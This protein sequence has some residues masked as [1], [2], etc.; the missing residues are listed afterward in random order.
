[1][2]KKPLTQKELAKRKKALA[3]QMAANGQAIPKAY[4]GLFN[5]IPSVQDIYDNPIVQQQISEGKF[6]QSQIDY[7]TNQGVDTSGAVA[8]ESA[9]TITGGGG[10]DSLT[11]STVT[12][13]GGNDTLDTLTGGA[14]NDTLTT[15]TVIGG[16]GNDTLDTSTVIGGGGND[17][18]DTVTGGGG[19]DTLTTSTVTGGG[20]N[21]SL[22]TSTVTGGGGNDTLDTLTGGNG[23]DSLNTVTDTT[24]VKYKYDDANNGFSADNKTYVRHSL[25]A[26]GE[27]ISTDY[28]ANPA[29]NQPFDT[30]TIAVDA[31][32]NKTVAI[33]NKYGVQINTLYLGPDGS[34]ID[35]SQIQASSTDSND[36]VWYLDENYN[37][38]ETTRGAKP[39]DT[40][41]FESKELADSAS[42]SAFVT[43]T[44]TGGGGNDTIT[45]GDGNDAIT[46]DAET[47]EPIPE[48]YTL[49]Y[50]IPQ[51]DGSFIYV[52]ANEDG[53]LL[54]RQG[55]PRSGITDL[56]F[57]P[58]D[59]RGYNA[60][61]AINPAI[62]ERGIFRYQDQKYNPATDQLTGRSGGLPIYDDDGKVVGFTEGNQSS[63][64][65]TQTGTDIPSAAQAGTPIYDAAGEI[66]GY[67][68]PQAAGPNQQRPI[69]NA[70]G[71][72]T[73]YTSG[74]QAN[75]TTAQRVGSPI[76]DAQGNIIGYNNQVQTEAQ[77]RL[78]PIVDDNGTITG[79]TQ[80]SGLTRESAAPQQVDAEG[81]LIAPVPS[82][83]ALINAAEAAAIAGNTA[84]PTAE[85]KATELPNRAGMIADE[86]TIVRDE[87]G[88]I[89]GAIPA[90]AEIPTAATIQ[91]LGNEAF[92]ILKN[93]AG[94]SIVPTASYTAATQT[95]REQSDITQEEKV[96][97]QIG[98]D[99]DKIKGSGIILKAVGK[100]TK[101]LDEIELAAAPAVAQTSDIVEEM[102]PKA[103]EGDVNALDTVRGQLAS[104]MTEFDDGTPDWAAG[105]IRVANQIMAERGLGNSSMAGAAILQAAQEAAL[106]I[107]Q[108]DAQV[109]ANMNLTNLSNQNKFAIDNAAAARNFKLS[110]L[111]NKQQAELSNS[112]QRFNFLQASLS[113]TQA[114]MV[115]NAQMSNALQE[116]DL[117]R[118]QQEQIANAARYSE[119]EN[120]NLTHDQQRRITDATNQ[121]QVNL[122][123]LSTKEKAVLAELQVQAAL[124]G[125]E[126]NNI[127]QT[128][129]LKATRYAEANNLDFTAEQ[130]RVFSNSKMVETIA[131]DN[132]EFNQTRTL[133]NAANYATMDM[134]NL[135]NRQQAQVV[136]AQSF[137]QMDLANLS[138]S[139]Q[140]T[141]LDAQGLQQFM[142][143]DTAAENAARQFNATSQN[144]V[145][146]FYEG[147]VADISK[148][149]SN[150]NAAMQQ[151]NAGQTNAMEQ[152]NATMAN[153]REQF[154]AANALEI[155][156]SNVAFRRELNTL[157]SAGK[158]VEAQA[159]AE[160]YFNMSQQA[161]AN[162]WQDYR[163]TF[164]YAFTQ[165]QND[166]DRAFNLSMALMNRDQ[167][168]KMFQ[169]TVDYN[170]GVA[171]GNMAIGL[172]ANISDV[173]LKTNIVK[174]KTFNNGL[175]WYTWD[176]NNKA[177]KLGYDKQPTE[178]FIAQEVQK[179]YPDTIVEKSNGTLAIM[180]KD[181]LRRSE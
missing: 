45:G 125:Q 83:G 74:M 28:P 159:L 85:I 155:E 108:A 175:G 145:D 165:A 162:V 161:M 39:A 167:E 6:N 140:A 177:T 63:F 7:F 120:M 172:M 123:N 118:S 80:A 81:N 35:A 170:T 147:L 133:Q 62:A 87:N 22:T 54:T 47:Q 181:V 4:A 156:Q 66:T 149:N 178:G 135:N 96:I 146:Q 34:Q 168:N 153:Q 77:Q 51:N 64:L 114:A 75:T 49:K 100:E 130:S 26:A 10:N 41:I 25:N 101:D 88:T 137:L 27:I 122:A 43:D 157:N 93:E 38:V 132:L 176:W 98:N 163:D 92:S 169:D 144:Q 84:V 136:N 48:G 106:P 76:L 32:G 105:S 46:T 36:K 102:F 79:Y 158:N 124:E 164:S 112:A 59:P 138:N 8:S 148:Y 17:T 73:G 89:I 57:N 115:A 21:D 141:I 152:Y 12:G 72:I 126:L 150:L 131:L 55:P 19:N 95:D 23:N 99:P 128:N 113:N 111:S 179:L 70:Q 174:Q 151:F 109:Y 71:E 30:K 119:L 91:T 37:V 56:V 104:M 5:N 60:Q 166:K 78:Q 127:Q 18:L 90:G 82:G 97:A 134:A 24:H 52:Y 143:T 110:D 86:V 33:F 58:N 40:V 117:S 42:A 121:M 180:F 139:Q 9:N 29:Y 116:Q 3:K 67:S 142:L 31:T 20:G 94:E 11:T 107:A 103:I 15:S 1:M 129:V 61:M 154:N 13:G 65:P 14:G 53:E 173:R 160:N 50:Q 68:S 44:I 171:L 2:P 69:Y 16:G